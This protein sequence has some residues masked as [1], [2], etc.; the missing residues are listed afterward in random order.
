MNPSQLKRRFLG[1]VPYGEA[2]ADI[3]DAFAEFADKLDGLV[4]DGPEKTI[5]LNKLI[6]SRDWS[7]RARPLVITVD[8]SEPP[9]RVED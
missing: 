2:V 1:Y 5:A 4:P 3:V 7:L 9:A 6:E 8:G